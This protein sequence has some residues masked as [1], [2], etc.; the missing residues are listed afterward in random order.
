MSQSRGQIGVTTYRQ[1][2][3]HEAANRL[4][5]AERVIALEAR[6]VALERQQQPP[7]PQP[8]NVKAIKGD[9]G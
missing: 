2:L 9:A 3:A 1:N 7:R 8:A 6:I 4:A 5:L